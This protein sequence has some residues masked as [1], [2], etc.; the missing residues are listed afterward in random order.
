MLIQFNFKNHKSFYE[1][2]TLDLTATSEQ[3]HNNNLIEVNGNKLL[4]YAII[5]GANASGKSTVI[6][7]FFRMVATLVRSYDTDVN[8]PI[9][10]VPF[11]FSEELKTKPS[12]F[13]VFIALNDIEYR[14]GFIAT[15]TEILEEWLYEKPFRKGTR[16]SEK[17]IFERE[18]NEVLFAKKYDE[19]SKFT[20]LINSKSL[21][22]SFLGR[23]SLNIFG[24]I[25]YWFLK[26][27]YINE[28]SNGYYKQYSLKNLYENKE[29][30]NE[31]NKLLNEIDPCLKELEIIEKEDAN[32]NKFYEAFGKHLNID[33]N[34]ELI[35][36]P[37]LGESDGTKKSIT[38][39]PIILTTLNEGGLLFIDELDIQLHALLL[40][41]IVDMFT[42]KETNKNNA[43][44]VFTSH[45]TFLMTSKFT[46]RDQ[47]IFVE[48]DN[49]TG[50][51]TLTS[52]SDYKKVRID[53]DY[54]G[55][56]FSGSFGSIP[57]V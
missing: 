50:K 37:L 21:M 8:E 19:N 45:N 38:L 47:I 13:E 31:F 4:P 1:K 35:S 57:F 55:N 48:K 17:M 36:L 29:L 22:L 44:L 9:N 16:A 53:N 42:N 15:K 52:L 10:V 56:Y 49:K 32:Q 27:D 41:K 28:S 39:L 2:A 43:Q 54:E 34:K 40:K 6:D 51:S 14:Y 7:A 25:Y 5:Y 23:K 46:R 18:K 24:D 3:N 26:T 12:E 33:N 30:H 20:T 11:L